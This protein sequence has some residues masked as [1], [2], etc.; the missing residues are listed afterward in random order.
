MPC[1]PDGKLDRRYAPAVI[2]LPNCR[3]HV[4][5]VGRVSLS[6]IKSFGGRLQ[7]LPGRQP[8][9]LSLLLASGVYERGRF[10]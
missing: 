3:H 9:A 2:N 4:N 8:D 1:P 6:E 7:T 5:R 10:R